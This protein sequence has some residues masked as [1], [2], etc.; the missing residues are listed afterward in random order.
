MANSQWPGGWREYR[1]ELAV[2]AALRPFLPVCHVSRTGA[3]QIDWGDRVID[4]LTGRHRG[5]SV[6]SGHS[7]RVQGMEASF[8]PQSRYQGV[9]G[10]LPDP[11]DFH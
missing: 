7:G 10:L 8:Q 11:L 1:G 6:A 2:D 9:G 4:T 5:S 3:G